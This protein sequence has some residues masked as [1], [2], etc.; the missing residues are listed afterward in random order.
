MGRDTRG[1][2]RAF[3]TLLKSLFRYFEKT[4]WGFMW[5]ALLRHFYPL[6][7][8][9][10]GLWSFFVDP[11]PSA[12]SLICPKQLARLPKS[13][14]YISPFF[15]SFVPAQAM[16][17]ILSKTLFVLPLRFFLIVKDLKQFNISS[18]PAQYVWVMS[19]PSFTPKG[20]KKKKG[21]MGISKVEVS[22]NDQ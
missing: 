1:P 17:S 16:T 6:R 15:F 2:Q 18:I 12:F 21:G 13:F 3:F 5:I 9:L 8:H 14:R 4:P 10:R 19:R 11:C 22:W 7:P 20:K